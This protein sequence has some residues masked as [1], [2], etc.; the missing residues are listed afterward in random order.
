MVGT[1]LRIFSER[2]REEIEDLERQSREQPHLRTAQRALADD[3]TDLV[4]SPAERR[5][6]TDAAAALFGRG[7]LD[8]LSPPV[9]A[10]VAQQ[11]GDVTMPWEDP[12]P[13]VA[14]VMAAAGVVPSKSAG[15]RAI[16]DGG[17][18]LNN[19]KVSDPEQTV[20]PADLLGGKFVVVRRG[21]RTVG[22]VRFEHQA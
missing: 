4:H 1:Y 22:A 14:D 13:R 11:L 15:R 10:A 9:L 3:I 8:T 5:A 6:A 16:A 2:G 7:E 20:T 17:A 18:Y 12:L 21:K 19:A